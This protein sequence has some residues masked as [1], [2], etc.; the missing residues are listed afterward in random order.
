MGI[1]PIMISKIE[2]SG[3][4]TFNEYYSLGKGR[5]LPLPPPLEKKDDDMDLLANP[6]IPDS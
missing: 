4:I 2:F 6:S 5:D 1:P 3:E